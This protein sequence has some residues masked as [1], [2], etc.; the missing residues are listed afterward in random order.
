MLDSERQKHAAVWLPHDLL[1]DLVL[2]LEAGMPASAP[3]RGV[4]SRLREALRQH[5]Q[6]AEEQSSRLQQHST[7]S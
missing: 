2:R 1:D 4:G 3:T 5:R 7:K 6:T